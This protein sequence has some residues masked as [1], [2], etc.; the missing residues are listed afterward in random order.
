MIPVNWDLDWTCR[1]CRYRGSP[2]ALENACKDGVEWICPRCG[3]SDSGTQSNGKEDLWGFNYS[4]TLCPL[5]ITYTARCDEC[6]RVESTQYAAQTGSIMI[7]WM[8]EG[9]QFAGSRFVCDRHTVSV[10]VKVEPKR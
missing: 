2:Y 8:P 4:T 7:R 1:R 10:D 9:W 5:W 3:S 6:G